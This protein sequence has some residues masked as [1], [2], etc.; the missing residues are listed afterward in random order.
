MFLNIK[1]GGFSI[2]Q[3]L[4]VLAIFLVIAS[5]AIPSLY[6][7]QVGAQVDTVAAEL[8]QSLRRAQSRAIVGYD[9]TNW[10]VYFEEDA[11][12]IYSGNDY[13]T[14]NTDRDESYPYSNSILIIN[15]FSDE[16]VFTRISGLP[17]S[18][19]NIT[20]S[21]SMNS[22]QSTITINSLGVIEYR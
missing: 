12:T 7:F 9:N 16:I 21:N 18:E 11:Y 15:D 5:M 4:L 3:V 20:L 13:N 8:G 22:D 17:S 1:Q 6:Q 14:R 19:G 10:G 2:V